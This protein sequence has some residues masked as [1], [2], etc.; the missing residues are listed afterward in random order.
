MSNHA[1]RLVD[2]RPVYDRSGKRVRRPKLLGQI[3]IEIGA[4]TNAE[5]I[6]A[7][8][9]QE[10]QRSHIGEILLAHRKITEQQLFDA[11]SIQ[12]SAQ[13]V[14]VQ[15]V[16]PDPRLIDLLGTDECLKKNI[17]PWKKLG[18][19]TVIATSDPAKFSMYR[20][21]LQDA[22]GPVL[23]ALVLKTKLQDTVAKGRTTA[24][25]TLAE[26]RV[27]DANSCRNW[28]T[29]S[30]MK[31][32]LFV[33]LLAAVTMTIS[34]PAIFV[35][36]C[37]WAILTLILSA[38]L[39][40]ATAVAVLGRKKPAMAPYT[41]VKYPVVSIMV[42][43]FKE[44][45][46]AGKL[47]Q[48]L[49]RLDYPKEALDICLVVEAEDDTTRQTIAKTVLPQWMRTIVVPQGSLKTKPRA[50]N[51][52]LDFCRGDIVGVYD[53]EDAPARDQIKRVV[54]RF[55]VAPDHV[56]CLQ[57][58]LDFYN[59][60]TN[61]LSRCFAVE[62]ATWFR[63]V[64]PGLQRL[65]MAVPLG[66][67]TLFFKRKALEELGRWDAH[68]VTEDADLGI[69][70]ARCG[71]TTELIDTVTEEEANC[72]PWA[73]VKQRSRWLKGY[74]M[75]YAVHMRSP[76]KLWRDLGFKRFLGFQ[77]LFLGALSQYA[78]APVLWSFWLIPMGLSHPMQNVLS[79]GMLLTLV[80]IFALTEVVNILLGIWAVR[81]TKHRGL[82]GWV[83]TLH[84]YFPLGA[85]AAYKGLLEMVTKPFYWDKTAHGLH[86]CAATP[87][88]ARPLH[89]TSGASQT[90]QKGDALG[91]DTPPLHPLFR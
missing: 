24:L 75:T 6:Q 32:G 30:L 36:L 60:K 13:I 65:G 59:A 66:G 82:M 17:L 40:I 46:I 81:Q 18:N 76:V 27:D 41:I 77:I 31:T 50:L 47:V 73:W 21:Q 83:P 54:R 55:E 89:Q 19:H 84:L 91:L 88:P 74:A 33:V 7:R 37:L 72:R 4:I 5:L 86:D 14:D 63:I 35:A 43:L 71:Y 2:P 90:P 85:T 58:V 87:P 64:L 16:P 25:V 12:Y 9:M 56:V 69:R 15:S 80:V 38:G 49:A 44:N 78:L 11:L 26:T 53:A 39:K 10:R 51:Y 28:N 23:M 8:A 68:N 42:P 57:G 20:D 70:L 1:V 22:F 3:L 29:R 61:W 48:R 62:Y 67:T 79:G 52:A 45:Q 34:P